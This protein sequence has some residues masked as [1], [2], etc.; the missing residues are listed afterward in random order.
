MMIG[1]T[2]TN[3][4]KSCYNSNFI[5]SL[6]L[7]RVSGTI[8]GGF[9]G[10]LIGMRL[11]GE[12]VE[13]LDDLGEVHRGHELVNLRVPKIV[14]ENQQ[15]LLDVSSGAEA[16]DELS[17]VLQPIMHLDGDDDGRIVDGPE[18][19]FIFHKLPGIYFVNLLQNVLNIDLVGDL[20][21]GFG[22][23]LL[24]FRLILGLCRDSVHSIASEAVLVIGRR[25]WLLALRLN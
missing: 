3:R 20:H 18:N 7:F 13:D 14:A 22:R 5:F 17:H 6:R 10:K 8:V 19:L 2:I 1:C 23:L 15:R 21:S 25:A 12:R 9:A 24:V 11:N 16:D 4:R